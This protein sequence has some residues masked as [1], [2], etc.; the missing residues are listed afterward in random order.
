MAQAATCELYAWWEEGY[1]GQLGHGGRVNVAV[2]RV[3]DG[4]EGAAAVGMSDGSLHS[5]VTTGEGRVA[6]IRCGERRAGPGGM[7]RG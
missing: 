6:S 5:P 7:G 2:P 3:L 1:S 4:I